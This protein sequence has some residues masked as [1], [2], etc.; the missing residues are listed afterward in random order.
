VNGILPRTFC[1]SAAPT[2]VAEGVKVAVHYTG[3]VEASGEQ[4]DSSQGRD[5]LEFEALPLPILL[6]VARLTPT[7][8]FKTRAGGNDAGAFF[9]DAPNRPQIYVPGVGRGGAND[10]W[11]RRCGIR[12]GGRGEEDRHPHPRDGVWRAEAPQAPA[13]APHPCCDRKLTVLLRL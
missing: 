3:R 13:P 4:F 2:V 1:D 7:T 6:G 9:C 8:A 12:N 5:P 10:P 11:V